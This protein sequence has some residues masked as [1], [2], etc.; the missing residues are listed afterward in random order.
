[1]GNAEELPWP[2]NS[3]E[4]VTG[5]SFL[6]L[7]EDRKAVLSEVERVLVPGGQ[8]TFL[9]PRKGPGLDWFLPSLREGFRFF[10][11][12]IGWQ[13][14]SGLHD[15]FERNDLVNLL[16]KAGLSSVECETTLHGLGWICRAHS[17]S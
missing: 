5:H 6:Y 9:E 8:I 11:T 14:F 16:S 15:R 3:F 4:M 10:A 2:D 17:A 13:I 1:M 12:M 7:L